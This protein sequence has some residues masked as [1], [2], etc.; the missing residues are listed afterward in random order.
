MSSSSMASGTSA[1]R[2]TAYQVHLPLCVLT[3]NNIADDVQ[4]DVVLDEPT[5]NSDHNVWTVQVVD[6]HNNKNTRLWTSP[7]ISS[8]VPPAVSAKF[9]KK[10]GILEVTYTVS[11]ENE[12]NDDDDD[13]DDSAA[14]PTAGAEFELHAEDKNKNQTQIPESRANMDMPHALFR[15]APYV[16]IES[17]PP[18]YGRHAVATQDVKVGTEVFSSL[19]YAAV[20][21][22]K[23]ADKLCHACFAPLGSTPRLCAGGCAFAAY[24]STECAA[25]DAADHKHECTLLAALKAANQAAGS[26]GL[27]L[28][29]RVLN[30]RAREPA[31]AFAAVA[32]LDEGASGSGDEAE[33]AR[34]LGMAGAVNKL[35]PPAS[36]MDDVAEL[37]RLIAKVHNNLHG[38]SNMRG[39]QVAHALYPSASFFNHSCWPSCVV[40]FSG[41][42][43]RVHCIDPN[44][45][46]AG[47]ILSIAYTEVYASE[48]VRAQNLL[49]KKGFRCACDRCKSP[50]DADVSLTAWATG[51][52]VDERR[53][54]RM[55]EDARN[56]LIHYQRAGGDV[57]A[58]ETCRARTASLLS[59]LEATFD[60]HHELC[61]ECRFLLMDLCRDLGRHKDVVRLT[62]NLASDHD[63]H[64]PKYHP[65]CALTSYRE[66]ESCTSLGDKGGSLKAYE[67][68]L[69]VLK[70]CYG[71][72][73]ADVV[74][75][76]KRVVDCSE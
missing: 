35:V 11:H 2:S 14:A 55:R 54:A 66:A 40:G 39:E 10:K 44:G 16:R 5:S 70:V 27:R 7:S 52:P 71:V 34:F 19:P 9:K 50:R 47:G 18:P 20:I 42:A 37:A 65:T 30:K 48:P 63:V 51:A 58:L 60:L 38:V 57:D 22:D 21:S 72:D 23:Y 73:H 74:E 36:R 56:A 29:A 25:N 17:A 45:V 75:V 4:V 13:D 46:A 33:R 53:E 28:F 8:K 59:R 1:C 26:R 61:H 62:R 49:E 67:G 3:N 69:S 41:R 31:E 68:C 12:K 24:C 76:Q 43:L 6:V 15:D 64:L 32:A